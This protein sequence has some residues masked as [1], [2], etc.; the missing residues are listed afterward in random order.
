MAQHRPEAA[1]AI[2]FI[3]VAIVRWTGPLTLVA[4][5]VRKFNNLMSRPFACALLGLV[6]TIATLTIGELMRA[7]GAVPLAFIV[8]GTMMI[9]GL[10]VGLLRELLSIRRKP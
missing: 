5:Q 8:G 6:W 7:K 3:V 9:G 1:C 4:R 2:A 10:A